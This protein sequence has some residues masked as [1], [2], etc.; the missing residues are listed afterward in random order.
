MPPRVGNGK[1]CDIYIIV[2]KLLTT[3]SKITFA[4][5]LTALMFVLFC[6]M[7]ALFGAAQTNIYY[8]SYR[9]RKKKGGGV[10]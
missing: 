9:N 1:H 6:R 7:G 2:A 4:F 3:Q 10:I 5:L 8:C